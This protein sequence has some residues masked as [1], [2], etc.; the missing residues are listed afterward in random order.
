MRRAAGEALSEGREGHLLDRRN[1]LLEASL[2]LCD[3]L[4]ALYNS[5]PDSSA[6][7]GAA[8]E[9]QILLVDA[10]Q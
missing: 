2:E 9:L 8:R 5:Q 10:T 4:A 6:A 1:L 3:C 7:V